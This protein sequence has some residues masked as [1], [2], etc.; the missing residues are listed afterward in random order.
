MGAN[1]ATRIR[2]FGRFKFTPA[3]LDLQPKENKQ[4]ADGHLVEVSPTRH[5]AQGK[6]SRIAGLCHMAQ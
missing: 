4:L 1:R 3:K 5:G 6:T 2:R